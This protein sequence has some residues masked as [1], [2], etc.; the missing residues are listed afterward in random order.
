MPRRRELFERQRR[1][2]KNNSLSRPS[3]TAPPKE[4]PFGRSPHPPQSAN[5]QRSQ[6]RVGEP[7]ARSP[8]PN[9]GRFYCL[10]RRGRRCLANNSL[11][12]PNSFVFLKE[13]IY[14][15]RIVSGRH[16]VQRSYTFNDD[17]D[18]CPSGFDRRPV[19]RGN[20]E[21]SLINEKRRLIDLII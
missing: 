17:H 2:L 16:R 1:F 15:N 9:R 13:F 11:S 7:R 20:A 3:P 12:F 18:I 6:V 21:R 8:F 14:R 5:P 10:P 4:E 19:I